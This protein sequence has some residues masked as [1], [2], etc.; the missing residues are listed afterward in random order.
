[1]RGRA[2]SGALLALLALLGSSLGGC[3]MLLPPKEKPVE[4]RDP[5]AAPSATPGKEEAPLA[6]CQV[7]ELDA[8]SEELSD[9]RERTFDRVRFR[10]AATPAIV[11]AVAAARPEWVFVLAHG[12]MN[13]AQGGRDFSSKLVRGI[14]DRAAKDGVAPAKVAFVAVHW[15][16]QRLVFHESAVNAEVIGARRVAPLLGLLADRVKGAKV[17]LVGHSLGGRLVLSALGAEG[18]RL[19]SRARAAVLLEAAADEDALL[20]A[21]T[22]LVGGFQGAPGRTLL[23]ANVHSRNDDVLELAYKNAMQ[24]P[25]LGREG[26]LRAAG[27]RYAGFALPAQGLDPAAL[28][29]ALK[30]PR[31]SWP[32]APDHRLV[33]VDATAVVSGHTEVMVAPIFDLI[34]RIAAKV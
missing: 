28:D 9:A 5:V 31:A 33:N 4:E 10:Y 12:W 26:A 29:A 15:D 6:D 27:E 24:S 22:T 32:D 1:V 18:E 25:A 34:W 13:D 3:A 30:D 21:H 23:I 17:V 19:V 2:S 7:L 11:D 16:S 8:L 14:L 20:P